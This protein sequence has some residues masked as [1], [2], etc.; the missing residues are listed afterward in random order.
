MAEPG[1]I[2]ILGEQSMERLGKG[3]EGRNEEGPG[4]ESTWARGYG[5]RKTG[6]EVCS[7]RSRDLE[8]SVNTL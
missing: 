2:K 6:R 4:L 7:G 8:Y 5:L 3:A 1:E